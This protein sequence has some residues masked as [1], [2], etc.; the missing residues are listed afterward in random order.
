M[1]RKTCDTCD[2]WDAEVT[3]ET[4]LELLAER[5]ADKRRIAELERE[6]DVLESVALALRDD[7]RE[8]RMLTVKLPPE[9]QGSNIPFAADGANAMRKEVVKV[10]NEACAKAGISLKIEGE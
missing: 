7:A 9:V 3:P 6:K 2:L 10:L 4:I 8:A 5:D 1:F